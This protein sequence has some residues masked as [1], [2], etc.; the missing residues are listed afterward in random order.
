MCCRHITDRM[1]QAIV[2]ERQPDDGAGI[3]SSSASKRGPASLAQKAAA[4][5]R[6]AS[7]LL[8]PLDEDAGDAAGESE[9]GERFQQR[10][11]RM[12]GHG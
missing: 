4:K 5:A 9:D 2:M 6:E 7:T 3:V 1:N 12:G 10:Q 8:T 11:C